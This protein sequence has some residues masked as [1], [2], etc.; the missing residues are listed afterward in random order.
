MTIGEVAKRAGVRA[1]AIRFYEKAGLL[2]EPVRSGGQRR[3]GSAILERLTLL[4]F[5]KKC[6]FTLAEARALF[7][8]FP[9]TAPVGP[10][11]EAHAAR[12]LAELEALGRRIGEMKDRIERGLACRCED[13]GE[14]ARKIQKR[15]VGSE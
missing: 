14:C 11:L 6:G 2:P 13:L 9:A 12:K 15:A 3:Y 4:E 8:D 10:R 5:A 7:D 1:S